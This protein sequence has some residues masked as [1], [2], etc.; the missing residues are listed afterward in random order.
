MLDVGT[1][2]DSGLVRLVVDRRTAGGRVTTTVIK[3]RVDDRQAEPEVNTFVRPVIEERPD[4]F[5]RVTLPNG[6]V[7]DSRSTGTF[8]VPNFNDRRL[9]SPAAPHR[10]IVI[11]P[12]VVQPF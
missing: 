4:V 7:V 9:G 8:F 1:T 12:G 3:E 5:F 11:R 10:L 6:D 2:D